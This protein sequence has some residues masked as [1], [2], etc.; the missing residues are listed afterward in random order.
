MEN[1]IFL[2]HSLLWSCCCSPTGPLVL[3]VLWHGPA[4]PVSLPSMGPACPLRA[5]HFLPYPHA[6]DER[7]GKA[8]RALESLGLRWNADLGWDSSS[9][10]SC[11]V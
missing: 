11:Y 5:P 7:E 9:T 3:P 8:V 2:Q 4:L 1:R 6:E 10:I